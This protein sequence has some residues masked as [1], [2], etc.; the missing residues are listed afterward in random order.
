MS[1]KTHEELLLGNAPEMILAGEQ[2]RNPTITEA[3]FEQEV[4]PILENP[5]GEDALAAYGRYVG[6]LTKPLKVLDNEDLDKVL[7]TVPALVQSPVTTIP[8][9]RGMSA[10]MFLRSLSRDVDLGGRHVN[11]KILNFMTHMTKVPDYVE[12]VIKPIQEIL[13][14]Y[15]RR[16]TAVPG[17]ESTA[18]T[19]PTVAS[20]SGSSFTDDYED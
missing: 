3:L 18:P 5:F 10:E 19:A 8:T 16:L 7:F 13:A 9:G 1:S 2:R 14:R 12:V 6:E 20:S 17:V 11:A 4:L 15:N